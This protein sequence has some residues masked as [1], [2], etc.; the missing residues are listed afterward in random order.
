MDPQ[1]IAEELGHPG[2]RNLLDSATL[3]RLAYN[4]SDGFSRVIPIGF[5]PRVLNT[6]LRATRFRKL[7]V[8]SVSS[9]SCMGKWSDSSAYLQYE[10]C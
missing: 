6:L 9:P 2:A 8:L 10:H 1:E 5:L 4:G 3:L 7:R